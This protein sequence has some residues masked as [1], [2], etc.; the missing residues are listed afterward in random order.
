[1]NLKDLQILDEYILSNLVRANLVPL[2]I[3]SP[4]KIMK[5]YDPLVSIQPVDGILLEKRL[6]PRF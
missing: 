2:N 5:P 3:C 4:M 1:M 6:G